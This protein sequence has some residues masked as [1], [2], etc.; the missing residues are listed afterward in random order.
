[1]QVLSV[2]TDLAG[3]ILQGMTFQKKYC[4]PAKKLLILTWWLNI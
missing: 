3:K 4:F 1:M 2:E